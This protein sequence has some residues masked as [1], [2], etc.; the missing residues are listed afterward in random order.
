MYRSVQPDSPPSSPTRIP[1]PNIRGKLGRETTESR[2]LT[3]ERRHGGSHGGSGNPSLAPMPLTPARERKFSPLSPPPPPPLE[4]EEGKKK[5]WIEIFGRPY[6][7]EGSWGVSSVCRYAHPRAGSR[8]AWEPRIGA[9]LARGPRVEPVRVGLL[10]TV[11]TTQPVFEPIIA[12]SYWAGTRAA[13]S[14]TK[15]KKLIVRT[16]LKKKFVRTSLKKS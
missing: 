4:R 1:T 14:K 11:T 13:D 9:H 7:M 3:Y 8:K 10:R 12:A 6:E 5:Q 15:N 16:C 2:T